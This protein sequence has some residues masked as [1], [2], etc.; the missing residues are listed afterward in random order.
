MVDSGCKGLVKY[1]KIDGIVWVTLKA[2][3]SVYQKTKTKTQVKR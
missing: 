1:K 2:K 3:A